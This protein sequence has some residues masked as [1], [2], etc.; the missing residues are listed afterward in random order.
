ML[1]VDGNDSDNLVAITYCGGI[2]IL[3]PD[4]R[5]IVRV[6]FRDHRMARGIVGHQNR[7]IATSYFGLEL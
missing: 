7:R 1:L 4:E 3:A 6:S 2:A 5:K